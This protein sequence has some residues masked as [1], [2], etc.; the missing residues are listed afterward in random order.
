M[1]K[2]T[3][4]IVFGTSHAIKPFKDLQISKITINKAG[5][6]TEFF[7]EVLISLRGILNNTLSRELQVNRFTKN[8][9]FKIFRFVESLVLPHLDYCAVALHDASS[10]LRT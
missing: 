9:N 8:F 7:D 4:A 1:E 5:E 2:Q 6:Q 10:T 3:K